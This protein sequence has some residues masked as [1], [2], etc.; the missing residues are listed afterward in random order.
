MADESGSVFA[1]DPTFAS[2]LTG[3]VASG[4]SFFLGGTFTRYLMRGL[5]AGSNWVH[6]HVT[7]SPDLQ[8]L[9]APETIPDL[10][11]VTIA[12]EW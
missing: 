10:S 2:G 5:N 7:G 4:S 3:N 6:W 1:F 8:A 11:T 12:A 9:Q